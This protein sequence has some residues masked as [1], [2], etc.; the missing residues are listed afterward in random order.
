MLCPFQNRENAEILTLVVIISIWNMLL[1]TPLAAQWNN[2]FFEGLEF[3]KH[4]NKSKVL[5]FPADN[6]GLILTNKSWNGNFLALIKAASTH[7]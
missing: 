1:T 7:I 4:V 3:E 6:K 5:G 2:I